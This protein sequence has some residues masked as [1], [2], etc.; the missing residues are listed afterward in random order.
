MSGI[1]LQDRLASEGD[2][3]PIVFIT[4]F[5]DEA[6]RPLVLKAGALCYLSKPLHE[7][8]LLACIERALKRPGRNL[9]S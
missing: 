2:C 6:I 5:P 3:M 4:A 9:A 7:Q 8:C 1:E